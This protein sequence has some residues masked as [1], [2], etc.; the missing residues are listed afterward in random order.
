MRIGDETLLRRVGSITD[1]GPAVLVDVVFVHGLGGDDSSTW[2]PAGTTESWLSW[3]DQDI[4]EIA[5]WALRYPAGPRSGQRMV[6]GWRCLTG[7]GI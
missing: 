6:K 3:L 2:T 7:Q 5:V 4:P 1:A